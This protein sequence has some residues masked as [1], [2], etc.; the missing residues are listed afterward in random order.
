MPQWGTT[1]P[2]RI[3]EP[4]IVLNLLKLLQYYVEF[5]LLDVVQAKIS[6]IDLVFYS[7]CKS[8]LIAYSEFIYYKML[9]INWRSNSTQSINI[10]R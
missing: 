7:F 8:L 5:N 1:G 2:N 10:G 3:E 6:P 4:L 9:I